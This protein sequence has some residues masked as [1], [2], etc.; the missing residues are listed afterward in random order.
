[1]SQSL[2]Q[3]PQKS[4]IYGTWI[5]HQN[6]NKVVQN[7]ANPPTFNRKPGIYIFIFSSIH[8]APKI[9][10]IFPIIAWKIRYYNTPKKMVRRLTIMVAVASH[11]LWA[12]TF[13]HTQVDPVENL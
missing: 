13:K 9:P 3:K 4:S 5:I 7:D 1:M 2:R 6:L 10:N 8:S 12:S 11:I